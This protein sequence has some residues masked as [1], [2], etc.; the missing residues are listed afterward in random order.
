MVGFYIFIFVMWEEMGSPNNASQILD[1]FAF[2]TENP[3]ALLNIQ[4][5]FVK[6]D[7]VWS[8][9][10]LYSVDFSQSR[11]SV[12]KCFQQTHNQGL[13]QLFLTVSWN[14]RA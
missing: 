2:L 3:L 5:V 12:K 9:T 1:L 8:L 10:Q 11:I 6:W 13:R 7:Q 14:L 4:A